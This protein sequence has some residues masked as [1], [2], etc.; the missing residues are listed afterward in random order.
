M[1]MHLLLL[2][3]MFILRSVVVHDSTLSLAPHLKAS[4]WTL[5]SYFD[6]K[7][8]HRAADKVTCVDAYAKSR[9][10]N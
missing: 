8:V 3:E 1:L 9:N 6:R 2:K 4:P 7:P 10:Y 5:E